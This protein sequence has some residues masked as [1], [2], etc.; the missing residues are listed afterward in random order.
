MGRSPSLRA[1]SAGR[2]PTLAAAHHRLRGEFAGRGNL[3]DR[4]PRVPLDGT[5]RSLGGMVRADPALARVDRARLLV[6]RERSGARHRACG[7]CP[8]HD[9]DRG[10]RRAERDRR[11]SGR[12]L[13]RRRPRRPLGEHAG[14]G[15]RRSRLATSTT[16][17]FFWTGSAT[18]GSCGGPISR[19]PASR[20]R[21]C[22][23]AHDRVR[24]RAG[25]GTRHRR[26]GRARPAVVRVGGRPSPA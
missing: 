11:G 9:A 13:R 24:P 12:V 19:P 17:R 4:G 1:R 23:V 18:R 22:R 7:N 16:S 5:R 20:S 15:M 26:D 25:N 8:G 14:A 6:V 10:R 21:R 2:R 3:S